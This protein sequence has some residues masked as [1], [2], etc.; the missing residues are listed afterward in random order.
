MKLVR[1]DK[2]AWQYRE[3]IDWD[4]PVRYDQDQLEMTS[5]RAGRSCS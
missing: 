5:S 4:E 1:P 3:H 2:L